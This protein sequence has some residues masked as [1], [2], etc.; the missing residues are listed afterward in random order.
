MKKYLIFLGALAM[1]SCKKFLDVNTN[2]NTP[3][4]TK[5]NYVFANAQNVTA[6]SQVGGP[7]SLGSTWAG[8]WGHSTSFTGGGQEK[9]YV[10]TT[11]DFN[12]FDGW[13]D[14]LTDYQYVIDH[15]ATDGFGYLV[16]PAKV[17]QCYTY[18][19][20]VDCYGNVP[21]S[22]ALKGTS[23][24]YPVYDDAKTIYESL[25]TKLTE[26]VADM[27]AATFPL[28]EQSDLMFKG[29]KANWIRF[30]NSL[31][32]RILIRQSN[33]A[34]RDSYITTAI[35]AITGGFITDNVYVNPGYTKTSGKLNPFYGNYGYDQNDAQTGTFAYRK[36]N[37][38]IIDWF[39]NSNDLWRIQRV[40]APKT[41]GSPTNFADYTGVP[42]GSAT[43][44]LEAVCASI[45]SEQIV[46]G[47]AGRSSILMSAAESYFL[48]AE[49][50]QRYGIASLGTAISNYQTGMRWAHRLAA[51]TQT[52][53][54]SATNSQADVQADSWIGSG[55]LYYDYAIA[56]TSADQRRTIQIQKWVALLNIDGLEAWSE[57]RRT[58]TTDGTGF[59]T[60]YGCCPYSPKSVVVAANGPEPARLYYTI[61]E[62][63]V[64]SANV[65]PITNTA[66]YIFTSKIFWDAN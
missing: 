64:N 13:Y 23:N 24:T 3:T 55:T 40:A 7:H 10:F 44:Y 4:V 14:N 22:Q 37:K 50:A 42:M 41:G 2:P 8:F 9:T 46:K 47:D 5:A 29:N 58:N 19:K 48:L 12:F 18:Q 27:N 11:N 21:Y 20:V 63:S 16:G 15:A 43:G 65:P 59:V 61:G 39:K 66:N 1:V 17:M 26:A 31:K 53:T 35:N 32:L 34:G 52:G 33:M 30:A 6:A 45:G 49:A 62:L 54:S 36:M 57:Y 60:A 28:N 51:A 25:I 38:V 56:G